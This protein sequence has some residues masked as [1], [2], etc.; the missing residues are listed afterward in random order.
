MMYLTG[1]YLIEDYRD[2]ETLLKAHRNFSVS[3]I[4]EASVID[5]PIADWVGLECF[6][7]TKNRRIVL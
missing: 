3:R 4:I 6:M 2:D 1:F 5:E 7:E